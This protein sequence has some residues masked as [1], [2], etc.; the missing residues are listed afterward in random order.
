M[1]RKNTQEDFW[2]CVDKSK[3]PSACWLWTKSKSSSGYGKTFYFG[4]V[5]RAHRL[6]YFFS[7]GETPSH[8]C[9]TCDN[10]SCVNP[11][12]LFAG[13]AKQN[14]RDMVDK[15]RSWKPKGELHPQSKLTREDILLMRKLRSDGLSFS[16]IGSRFGIHR[17]YA[18]QIALGLRW[19]HV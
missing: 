11:E 14:S 17:N 12:H 3:G 16:E 18:R 19:T 13:T 1:P 8:V 6:A 7:H 4:K 15:G 10:P 5:W 2:N 9:H